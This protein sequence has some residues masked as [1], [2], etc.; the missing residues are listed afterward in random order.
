MD[1]AALAAVIRAELRPRVAAFTSR[2]GRPP[3]LAVVLAG[4]NPASEIYV[5]HKLR[6]LDEAGCRAQLVRL[7]AAAA[8]TEVLDAVARLNTDGAVDGI[9]VQSPLPT[10]MGAGAEQRVF[11]AIDPA[12]DV[13]GFHPSN[14]G[15]LVQN[16]SSLVACTPLGCLELL[17]RAGIP[18]AGRH[19]VIIGRS[20][21]VGKP[22]ALLLL[23]RDATVTLCHSRTV[24]LPAVAREAD[25]LVAAIGRPA[26]VTA[27]FVKPGATVVDV[28]ITRLDQASEV[29]RLF[30]AG[31]PRRRQFQANGSLLVG[32]VHPDVEEVA[33]ALTPVPGG[34]GPLTIAM[35]LRNT[36]T[37][38]ENRA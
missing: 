35:V 22:M 12:K 13:D 15:L 9:L 25:I 36:L 6:A 14:V 21:I 27:E 34:V 3:G 29:E 7:D 24:D 16:R 10:E 31:H 37:A 38:A 30:P 4:H 28:G 32:D 17:E 5:R 8:F 23:H 2:R 18:L 20:N 11:D 1:G 19:A 33:G 26:F